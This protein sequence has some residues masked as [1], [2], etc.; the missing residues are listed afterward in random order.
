M[1]MADEPRNVAAQ[2][3]VK[4]KLPSLIKLEIRFRCCSEVGH[5]Q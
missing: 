1:K 2:M 3:V 4:F 5:G